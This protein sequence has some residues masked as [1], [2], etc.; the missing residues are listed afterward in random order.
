MVS[1][2]ECELRGASALTHTRGSQDGM[3]VRC[4][5]HGSD[6]VS[7]V[8]AEDRA[9][10]EAIVADRNRAQKHDLHID[11]PMNYPR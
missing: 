2:F 1:R 11:A 7:L 10:L 9:R 5:A 6:S 8:S 4:R 3:D